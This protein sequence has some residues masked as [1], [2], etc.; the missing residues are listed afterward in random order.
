MTDAAKL[1]KALADPAWRLNNLYWIIDKNGKKVKFVRNWAQEEMWHN[2]HNL[3]LVLKAR[4]LGCTTWW[5]IYMLDRCLFNSHQACGLVAHKQDDAERLFVEKLQ[6]AYDNLPA[7]IKNNRTTTKYEAGWIRLN[8]GSS[9]RVSTS[10]RSG[11][12]QVLHISEFAKICAKYPDKAKEIV[13]G[14]LNAVGPDQMVVIESTAEGNHGY[15]HDYCIKAMGR[16]AQGKPM[17]AM[18]WKMFF[19]SWWREKL[20]KLNAYADVMISDELEEYFAMLL[21]EKGI[22]LT[23]QQKAWYSKKR[24]DMTN[25]EDMKREFP[26]YPEEAFDVSIQGAYYATQFARI[27][28]DGRIREVPHYTGIPVDTWWDLGVGDDTVIW[29]TQTVGPMIHAINFYSNSGEG[30]AH[31]LEKLQELAQSRHYLYG[32]MVAPHDIIQRELTTG[33]SRYETAREMG[34]K[35]EI[36]PKLPIE[37]GI[38]ACRNV[39]SVCQFDEKNCDE[40]IRGLKEYRKQWNDKTESW[41]NSPLHNWASHY[42]DGFRTMAVAHRFGSRRMKVPMMPKITA[43]SW[44]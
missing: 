40:G 15:F 28:A 29:F 1:R 13:T 6:F 41:R 12:L 11:T 8:N 25:W 24:D 30:L 36:A 32:R 20:Y 44:S 39:L 35:F 17:T 37:D 38:E 42:A 22:S 23:P 3:N 43:A 21:D 16:M 34:M 10:M 4:Q 19:F 18:D 33:K 14:S 9:L 5:I 27:H 2:R 31:Y 7:A 26:S